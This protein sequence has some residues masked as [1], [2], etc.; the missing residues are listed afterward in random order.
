MFSFNDLLHLQYWR[1]KVDFL[2]TSI[3]HWPQ[4]EGECNMVKLIPDWASRRTLVH[5]IV[6]CSISHLI[7]A[8]RQALDMTFSFQNLLQ[9]WG[10]KCFRQHWHYLTLM[11]TLP[12]GSVLSQMTEVHAGFLMKR[13]VSVCMYIIMLHLWLI[14]E[15]WPS[16][17]F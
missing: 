11:Q 14:L 1:Q 5:F 7:L 16:K 6:N 17:L 4:R 12:W 2:H 15:L 10:S 3:V 9:N 13:S 8:P